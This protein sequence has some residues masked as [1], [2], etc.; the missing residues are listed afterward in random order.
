MLPFRYHHYT[1]N[2]SYVHAISN[3]ILGLFDTVGLSMMCYK[4]QKTSP[5]DKKELK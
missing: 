1:M 3:T 2:I 5:L 4:N